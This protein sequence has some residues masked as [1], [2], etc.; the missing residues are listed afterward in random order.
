MSNLLESLTKS[1]ITTYT[2]KKSF[3]EQET[4][5]K[6]L[7]IIANH[8]KYNK[9]ESMFPDTGEYSRDK[10]KKHMDFIAAGATYRERLLIAG[11]RV[12]KSE[13]GAYEL[14][15]HATG[16]YPHWWTG[17]RFTRP[18]Q[19]WIGGDTSTTVRDI[20][21]KKL[22][23]SIGD[24]GSGMINKSLIKDTRPRR[25]VPDAIETILVNHISGGVSSV[26]LKT[27]EQGRETWQGTE[28]DLIW[29][30]EEP[31][32]EI[33]SEALI[34]TMTTNGLVM[35][36]F[37]PLRG[38]SDVV[39]SFMETDNSA[40]KSTS[41][42]TVTATWADA[43][44][45]TE[46]AKEE[47]RASIPPNERDAREN[48]NPVLGSGRIYPFELDSVVV[49]DFPIPKYYAKA[50]GMDVGWNKTAVLWGALDR[51][52]DVLYIYSEHYAG[53][54]EPLLHAKSVKARGEWIKG[55][56]DP[57]AR[58][59]SQIDG[60]KL[61][62]IYSLPEERGGCGLKIQHAENAVEAGIYEVWVRLQTGRL[63]IFKSCTNLLKELS[64]YHRNDKGVVVK[65]N[66]HLCDCL[67]YLCMSGLRIASCQ[68]E[69]V[70]KKQN[71]IN[72][73]AWN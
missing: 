68:I 21:Q 25:N 15:C 7:E 69:S 66:D 63:K 30:D 37:T 5:I 22:L 6:A 20:I 35:L 24:F 4:L 53:E 52:Q 51:D 16:I 56:I 23:G 27:Y 36:T 34:R 2:D 31:P 57:A 70:P 40:M 32:L 65:K 3:Q 59:R 45:L 1:L 50:Y 19:A 71:V 9:F 29:L 67:R 17:K 64:L 55:V 39:L 14:T 43:P 72:F 49:K 47:L 60:Q 41:K 58:G 28:I 12:G 18:I 44:H 26:V 73:A 46:Q 54:Q 13:L 33:Y 48:G 42:Y 38:L 11:N 10:Y 62:E 8:A 61:F